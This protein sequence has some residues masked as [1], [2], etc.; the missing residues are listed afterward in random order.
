MTSR[1]YNPGTALLSVVALLLWALT[2]SVLCSQVSP[3]L[4]Q[5]NEAANSG[6][7]DLKKARL[8]TVGPGEREL[9]TNC[10]ATSFARDEI[11][12]AAREGKNSDV[13]L[14]ARRGR[15]EQSR[16]LSNRRLALL[17]YNLRD[18]GVTRLVTAEGDR[19]GG[20]GRIEVYLEG[21][22]FRVFLFKRNTVSADCRGI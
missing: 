2:P 8:G 7:A 11:V 18:F 20:L 9:P 17:S 3:S 1:L 16:S 21:R 6:A 10:E 15:G 13:I 12:V 5:T 14:I 22:L 19:T 4:P